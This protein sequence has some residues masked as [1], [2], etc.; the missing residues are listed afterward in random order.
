MPILDKAGVNTETKQA[1]VWI[2]TDDA[3]YYDLGILVASQ[4]GFG[5]S[6]VINEVETVRA[7]RICDEAGI[8]I[9]RKRIWSDKKEI[10]SGLEDGELKKWLVSKK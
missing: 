2:V 3:D 4:F 9:K 8:D 7:L 5:G 10:L 1:A 6:R